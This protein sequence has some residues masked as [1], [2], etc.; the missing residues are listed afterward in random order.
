MPA[1]NVETLV[2]VFLVSLGEVEIR[3]LLPSHRPDLNRVYGQGNYFRQERGRLMQHGWMPRAVL[4]T[5]LGLGVM[6]GLLR[7]DEAHPLP[8]GVPD[9]APLIHQPA[10]L[11]EPVIPSR[12]AVLPEWRV[13]SPGAIPPTSFRER[14]HNCITK[15][16]VADVPVFC[17]AHHNSPGCGNFCSEF[18]FIFGSC[19]TF[20][21]ERCYRGPPPVPFVP[22]YPY[23]LGESGNCRCP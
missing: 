15:V 12:D 8:A 4:A 23:G 16:L 11:A 2:R 3:S 14:V 9:S 21:G 1:I 7:A 6:A 13:V 22:G 18:N 5:V 19:R 20:Y 17:W 10:P